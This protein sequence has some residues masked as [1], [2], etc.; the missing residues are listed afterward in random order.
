MPELYASLVSSLDDPDFIYLTGTPWQFY[1]FVH[2]FI[3]ST[4][5]TSPIINNNLTVTDV[6]QV[7]TITQKTMNMD[8]F[9]K[10]NTYIRRRRR[11]LQR[12]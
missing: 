9:R 1:S 8:G 2:T 3:H 10:N 6:T 7:F 4:F 5:S 11:S 12:L